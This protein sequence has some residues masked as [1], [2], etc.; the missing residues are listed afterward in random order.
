MLIIDGFSVMYRAY[1]SFPTTLTLPD[2][3]P[4]N[5][6]FGFITLAFKAIDQLN[7][8]KVCI[9]F[10]RPE[11]TLRK[12]DYPDYKAHRK[13]PPDEFVQQI[14]LLQ[15][16]IKE[17]G[18][19]YID[20]PGYEADDLMGT[21]TQIDPA[22]HYYLL[23]ND[24]DCFQLVSDSVSVMSS[25]KGEKDLVIFTPEKVKAKMGVTV[26]Q[27]VDYKALRGDAS[28]NI[29]GVKGIGD[30]TAIRL[31]TD[32]G[33]LNN[34]YAHLD[35]I[36]PLGVQSKLRDDRD[37]AYVSQ[38]LAT[39]IHDVPFDFSDLSFDYQ[40]NWTD[41][42]AI[43]KQYQFTN[44]IKKYAHYTT[45]TPV[46]ASFT[47]HLIETPE[48]LSALIPHMHQGVAIDLETTSLTAVDAQIVGISFCMTTTDAYYIAFNTFFTPPAE[49]V[50][51][52]L[53]DP[54]PDITIDFAM[55]PF[56]TM[57]KPVLENPD[58]PKI[59]HNGKYEMM[60]L[61]NYGIQLRGIA[62]DTMLAAY[63]LYPGERVGLKAL[64]GRY[65]NL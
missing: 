7:P 16:L 15:R 47:A 34:I 11:P 45:H 55:N 29:P 25:Q 26:S 5:A 37:N 39:I 4:I 21:L 64:A 32:Y 63:I 17:L 53:F 59:T 23:T 65:L 12:Q 10:D 20:L 62:F 36:T 35:H 61:A 3:T 18:F 38:Q 58:I 60:V 27:I 50:P 40:P 44:L 13:P 22:D 42:L 56:L 46:T 2:S 28:D 31:L 30:K 54:I 51:L 48:A 14:P 33:T 19:I 9:C 6:V 57:L 8:D 41:I 1:Y 52:T 49:A 24:Q 43:F